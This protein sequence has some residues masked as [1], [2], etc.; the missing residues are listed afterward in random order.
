MNIKPINKQQK[1]VYFLLHYITVE[2]SLLCYLLEIDKQCLKSHI[3][4]LRRTYD[5]MIHETGASTKMNYE[6]ENYDYTLKLYKSWKEKQ[7]K[8]EMTELKAIQMTYETD[9]NYTEIGRAC[10]IS[11]YAVSQLM[12]KHRKGLGLT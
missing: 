12:K 9:L 8:K 2:E 5:I 10:K 1:I 7:H 6:I 3:V 11:Y 4:H